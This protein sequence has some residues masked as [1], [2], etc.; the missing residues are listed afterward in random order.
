MDKKVQN[1]GT[2]F[3][4]L[5]KFQNFVVSEGYLEKKYSGRYW[6]AGKQ[7]ATVERLWLQPIP[8]SA[9]SAVSF[10]IWKS[11]KKKLISLNP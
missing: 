11:N 2:G 5:D 7:L 3:N 1:Q 8:W 9:K 4:S 10:S 6:L